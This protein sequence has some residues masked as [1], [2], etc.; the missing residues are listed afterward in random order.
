MQAGATDKWYMDIRYGAAQRGQ[1][2]DNEDQVVLS[3]TRPTSG[4]FNKH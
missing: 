3:A 1:L 2:V 4:P